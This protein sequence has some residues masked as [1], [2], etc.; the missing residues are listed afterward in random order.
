M[1]MLTTDPQTDVIDAE[2]EEYLCPVCLEIYI[3]PMTTDCGHTFCESCLKECLRPQKPVCAVCRSD[4]HK[5]KK[6][7]DIQNEMKRSIG[8][9][10]G[11]KNEVLLSDMRTHTGVC[12]KYQDFIKEGMKAISKNQPSTVR[13]SPLLQVCPI[14]ASMPWGDPNYR[15]ADFFQHL[16]MRHAFS[17]DTFVDYSTDEQAMI[18]EALQRSLMEN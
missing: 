11:C 10:K 14:C 1:A 13:L 17:Y 5:W 4:L 18:Q 9:C 16:R 12:S 6:A 2:Y 7:D 15:S 8:K 3:S